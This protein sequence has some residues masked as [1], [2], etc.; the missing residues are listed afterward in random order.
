MAEKINSISENPCQKKGME[1]GATKNLS[2]N[3]AETVAEK[4]GWGRI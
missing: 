3:R 4:G 1:G 2:E